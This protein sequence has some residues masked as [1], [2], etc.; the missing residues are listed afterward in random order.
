MNKVPKSTSEILERSVQISDGLRQTS[1]DGVN[2]AFDVKYGIMF[3]LYMPGH[4][5]SYG[6]SRGRIA[7]TY[8]PASQP[9]NSVTIE[10]ASGHTEYV[11]NIISLGDG[12]VRLFYEE[13]SKSDS[14]HVL[15]YKDY[16][17]LTDTL[18][19]AK[20]IML[21]KDDGSVTPLTQGEEFRYLEER[22]LNDH[23]YLCT[24]QICM[25]GHTI[26]KGEDGYH[27]GSISTYLSE[28]I[29]Y[30]SADNLAT[31]EFFA[32]CPYVSQYEFDYKILDGK[33]Y[34]LFRTNRD[35]NAISWTI[36]EDM[37]KTW[38]EPVEL[39]ESIQCRPRVI[40]HNGHILMS[41]NYFND[42]TGNRPPIQ[43][44][45]TSIRMHLGEAEN[46]YD[47]PVVADLYSRYGIVNI[48]LVDVYGDVYMAYSTSELALECQ[49]YLLQAAYHDPAPV[50]RGK[51]AV[52]YVK[53]GDLTPKNYK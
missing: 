20:T 23:T 50:G 1:G 18:T 41:Y 53:L 47:N 51:D 46:P 27:Y 21:K 10:V 37:G 43:Q 42:D 34:A 13:D 30:R 11:P 38:S 15:S 32:V 8:F 2:M 22:G 45:R 17:Y 19:E 52:R 35:V 6:E 14:D 5:G 29:L 3:C 48:A 39:E 4:Q 24:E 28:V 12:K 40:V 31:V 25:G 49:N 36:S 26:F 9:T 7:L 33:I 16:D 44:G